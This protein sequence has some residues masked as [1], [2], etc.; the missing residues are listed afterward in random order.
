MNKQEIEK[1][2]KMI[3][4][5]KE[6]FERINHG[7]FTPRIQAFELAISSLTQQLNNGWIPIDSMGLPNKAGYY[8]VTY[9]TGKSR[10][11]EWLYYD[12]GKTGK[13]LLIADGYEE[14]N[15]RWEEE[16]KENVT[17]WKKVE[18]YKQEVSE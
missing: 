8:C 11:T 14:D 16:F 18:P 5:D 13:W 12:E 10:G 17:A 9:D 1:A 15:T 6:S 7:G 2:I 3:T 4:D